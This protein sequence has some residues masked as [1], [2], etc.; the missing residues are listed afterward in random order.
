M[1]NTSA[2]LQSQVLCL[3]YP[4]FGKFKKVGESHVYS[5]IVIKM[6]T[7]CEDLNNKL[8]TG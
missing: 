1:H 2:A 5:R 3:H 4:A 6:R 8:F 7:I